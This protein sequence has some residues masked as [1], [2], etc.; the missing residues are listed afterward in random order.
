[1][2]TQETI[3]HVIESHRLMHMATIDK[4]GMPC[5]RGVDYASDE[6]LNLFFVTHKDTRKVEQ[7]AKNE[8]ISFVIDHDCE[9]MSALQE[10]KYIKGSGIASEVSDI[11]TIQKAM[12]LLMQKMPFLKDLPLNPEEMKVI[13]VELK[14]VLVTDNTVSFGHT[15]MVTQ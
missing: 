1:M 6:D 9:S 13:K 4:N 12:G 11:E 14:E 7:I 8:N 15:E 5:V 10:L 3:K 2:N